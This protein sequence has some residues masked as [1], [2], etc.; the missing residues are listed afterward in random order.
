MRAGTDRA[1]LERMT[2]H[3]TIAALAAAA[4]LIGAAPA[5]ADSIAYVKDGT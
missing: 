5:A 1:S 3:A 2:S 4:A